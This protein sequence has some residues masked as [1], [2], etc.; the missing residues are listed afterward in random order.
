MSGQFLILMMSGF[1]VLDIYIMYIFHKI[2]A[3]RENE[4]KIELMEQQEQ[5]QLQMYQELRK[6]YQETHAVAH[7]I[8]RHVSALKALIAASPNQ[9]AE[10]YL[11]DLAKT[12]KRLKPV[13]RNQNAILEIILNT[14]A[15]RCEKEDISL[16]LHIDDF[17][18]QFISD[19][20]ITTIFSNILDN[21]VGCLYG[22]I[23]ISEEN[24]CCIAKAG[25][26][27]CIADYKCL[28]KNKAL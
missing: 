9:Q 27:D 6:K 15:A 16:E 12:T 28:P 25:R 3:S 2:S 20:D 24:R 1:M 8:N 26:I 7:D 18:L 13:I 11:S 5:L 10:T 23:K 19:M 14:I 17:P 4:K 22:N 21:A